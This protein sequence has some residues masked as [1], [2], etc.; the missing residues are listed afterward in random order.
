MLGYIMPIISLNTTQR[1]TESKA[2]RLANK[3]VLPDEGSSFCNI[4]RKQQALVDFSQKLEQ[5][6]IS[7]IS[8]DFQYGKLTLLV[9][10]IQVRLKYKPN[11]TLA[12]IP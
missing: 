9:H 8:K 11:Q 10:I 1:P 7:Q 6:V 4:K 5:K 12:K 3:Y 2:P